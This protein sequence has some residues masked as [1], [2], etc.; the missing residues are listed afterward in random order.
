[1]RMPPHYTVQNPAL[2]SGTQ[3]YRPS[4][5]GAPAILSVQAQQNWLSF[6]ARRRIQPQPEYDAPRHC[7]KRHQSAASNELIDLI[8][9]WRGRTM[10]SGG[11][12][13]RTRQR[14]PHGTAKNSRQSG[15]SDG[16]QRQKRE[17]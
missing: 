16:S 1:M 2:N 15:D 11:L 6:A 5:F 7:P 4:G 14:R 12:P 9:V 17:P 10:P 13:M 8:G 3:A